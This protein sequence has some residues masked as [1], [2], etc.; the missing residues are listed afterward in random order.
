MVKYI[1]S[2][3]FG[4]L[5]FALIFFGI[6]YLNGAIWAIVIGS[7]I[8]LLAIH[9]LYSNLKNRYEWDVRKKEM[10]ARNFEWYVST[11]PQNFTDGHVSCSKC[12]SLAI[13]SLPLNGRHFCKKCNHTLFYT[14]AEE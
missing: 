10:E 8:V 12:N 9:P 3:F 6:D 2:G 7:I 11:F 13:V 1:L 4:A 5:G 14:P